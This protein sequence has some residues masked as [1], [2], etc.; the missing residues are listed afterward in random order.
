MFES[1]KIGG[2]SDQFEPLAQGVA[3]DGRQRLDVAQ[4]H[5]KRE[6]EIV[7]VGLDA[8][9]LS[10]RVEDGHADVQDRVLALG[11]VDNDEHHKEARLFG[12]P[13]GLQDALGAL[14]EKTA[15]VRDD[16]QQLGRRRR[17]RLRRRRRPRLNH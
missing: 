10:G 16:Q 1:L 7:E 11:I 14:A 4:E 8:E 12:A 13:D 9:Q 2:R 15:P 6:R 3:E 5:V 17:Q